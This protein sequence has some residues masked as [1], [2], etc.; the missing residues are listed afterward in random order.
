[1]ENIKFGYNRNK[2]VNIGCKEFISQITEVIRS[3]VIY[4]PENLKVSA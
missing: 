4:K 1:M 2:N 3:E